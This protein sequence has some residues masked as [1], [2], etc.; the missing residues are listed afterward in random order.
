MLNLDG[1]FA[2]HPALG[3][4]APYFAAGELLI[5]PATG[6]AGVDRSHAAAQAALFDGDVDDGIAG[7]ASLA[8]SAFSSA[9]PAVWRAG[10][11]DRSIDLLSD[12]ALANPLLDIADLC[13]EPAWLP[14]SWCV[15]DLLAQRSAL[16]ATRFADMAANAASALATTD[17]PRIAM[18]ELA[19]F[20][21]H[22][23]Q[24]GGSGRLARALNA[25]AD[26]LVS[27]AEASGSAWRRTVVMVVT[28]F[29][30]L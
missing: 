21:T 9:A 14:G 28:E 2:L 3:P 11:S 6:I 5:I 18:L 8:S 23:A 16:D 4:L 13:S 15:D 17:G 19:G 20:D 26:G 27:L 10:P 1:F 22:V 30:R 7:W 29:G 12:L 24:G 25:L